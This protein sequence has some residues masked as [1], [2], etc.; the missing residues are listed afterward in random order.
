MG[1]HSF[2]DG[3]VHLVVEDGFRSDLA[4]V[5]LWLAWLCPPNENHQRAALFHDA[6]YQKRQCSR[7]TADSAFRTIMAHDN[8]PRWRRLLM[9]YAVRLFGGYA[10]KQHTESERDK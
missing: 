8:V 2:F 7:F 1:E 5:P 4:S 10:W 9:Y 6:A 3:T